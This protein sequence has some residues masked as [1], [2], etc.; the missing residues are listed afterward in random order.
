MYETGYI[1]YFHDVK[2]IATTKN[3]EKR[4][5]RKAKEVDKNKAAV[6]EEN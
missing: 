5:I 2:V 1:T 4:F 3:Y 6:R